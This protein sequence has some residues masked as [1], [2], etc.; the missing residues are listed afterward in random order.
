MNILIIEDNEIE[1][2]NLRI[3]L[4]KCDD[5]RLIG[6][7]DTIERGIE[8]ANRERPDLLLLDIQLECENS[9]DHIHRLLYNPYIICATL[10]SEHALKAF[11]VGVSDY[12][13]K[14]ITREKLDCALQRILKRY[15][16][17]MPKRASEAISLS[18][19]TTT[20][21][22]PFHEIIKITADGD[23]TFVVDEHQ[24]QFI[25]SR[26]MREW[27]ELLPPSSFIALDRSTIVNREKIVSFTALTADR[28]ATIKFQNGA[29][30]QI[31]P[32]ALRRLKSVFAEGLD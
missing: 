27:G 19:G 17:V 18:N 10:Y 22:V 23:Y 1:Q 13:T 6:M 2:E 8:M 32:T 3:P 4:E 26:R 14:P 29:T 9:L 21:M 20:Q 15:G 30:H 24:T 16:S 5:C 12:L 28:T 25:C 11:E 31:G 7:A